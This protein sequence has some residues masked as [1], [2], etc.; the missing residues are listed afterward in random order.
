MNWT[1]TRSTKLRNRSASTIVNEIGPWWQFRR[2]ADTWR[3]H[4]KDVEREEIFA[5]A[6]VV[7]LSLTPI[8][9]PSVAVAALIAGAVQAKNVW[10]LVRRP[11][12]SAAA[13]TAI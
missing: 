3:S 11:G 5:L 10:S 6:A 7:T 2:F 1:D 12:D 4:K 13:R 9:A 8:F